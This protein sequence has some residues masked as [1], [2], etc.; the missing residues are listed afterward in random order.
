[1]EYKVGEKWGDAEATVATRFITSYDVSNSK[2]L[3]LEPFF[4]SI[5]TF[6]P[7]LIAIS[8]KK[9]LLMCLMFYKVSMNLHHFVYI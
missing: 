3:M 2:S 9:N 7:D 8:G 1:M 4:E 6:N 5:K